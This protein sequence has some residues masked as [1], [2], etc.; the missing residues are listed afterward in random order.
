M[1]APGAHKRMEKASGRRMS[2]ELGWC[3]RPRPRRE[4]FCR[5]GGCEMKT[6]HISGGSLFTGSE[7]A[8]A[9][10]TYSLELARA[11]LLDV[12]EIPFVDAEGMV[13]RAQIRVGWRTDTMVTFAYREDDELVD[14]EAVFALLDKVELL[15]VHRLEHD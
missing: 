11:E 10:M 12:V 13:G 7:I 15:H 14:P 6:I 1:S 2:D 3:G 9:V 5:S 8:D 4:T